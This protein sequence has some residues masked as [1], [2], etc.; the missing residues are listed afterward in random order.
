[1]ATRRFPRVALLAL[2]VALLPA[3]ASAGGG[4]EGAEAASAGASVRVV[5]NL[6]PPAPLTIRA[7]PQTGVRQLVGNVSPGRTV[8]LDWNVTRVAGEYRL[9]AETTGGR[10]I[11][12]RPFFFD[13]SGTVE[14][15]LQGNTIRIVD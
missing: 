12:S 10:D 5:N 8:V 11:V 7:V 3:C 9:L 14:W 6:I 15:T 4:M 13:G 1:M 2:A